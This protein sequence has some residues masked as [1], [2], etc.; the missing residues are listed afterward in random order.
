MIQRKGE[1]WLLESGERTVSIIVPVYNVEQYLH[2]TIGSVCEQTYSNWELILVNDGSKDQSGSI[3]DAYAEKNSRI[4]V[5]HTVN[6]GVSSARN[7]GIENACGKWVTF[8]DS[9]DYLNR[10]CLETLSGYEKLET[11]SVVVEVSSASHHS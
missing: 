11:L 4:R 7:L 3:C 9:D 10:N 5:F 8:L 2:K 6:Q 1:C